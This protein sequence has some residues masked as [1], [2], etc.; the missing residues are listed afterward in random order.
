MTARS[1][2]HIQAPDDFYEQLVAAHSGLAPEQS[3]A[4]NARLVLCLA[5][6]IGAAE[7]LRACL[8]MAALGEGEQ[9]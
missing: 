7:T 9:A 4:F 8:A 3:E 5:N 2:L 6:Q 1:D